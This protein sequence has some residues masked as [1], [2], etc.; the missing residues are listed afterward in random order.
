MTTKQ[1]SESFLEKTA[2]EAVSDWNDS[3]IF[4]CKIMSHSA[5]QLR[6]SEGIMAC[7][8]LSGRAPQGRKHVGL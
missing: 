8:L 3:S 4:V 2:H 7:R 1:A 5:V 6:E